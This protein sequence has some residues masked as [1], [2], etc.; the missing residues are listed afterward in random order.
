[1]WNVHNILSLHNN[2]D[3]PQLVH[4]KD[5]KKKDRT[6]ESDVCDDEFLELY[7]PSL[8]LANYLLAN[9]RCSA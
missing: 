9:H 1:M 8:S 5:R 7:F 6:T 3:C 2:P 4:K